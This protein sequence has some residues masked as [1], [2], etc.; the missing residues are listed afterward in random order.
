MRTA[1]CQGPQLVNGA[2][3]SP[4][5]H[6]LRRGGLDVPPAG[7]TDRPCGGREDR[8]RARGPGSA[9]HRC[10]G[11][12][13]RGALLPSL[14]R[15]AMWRDGMGPG[16]LQPRRSA[17]HGHRLRRH[18]RRGA[19]HV[20]VAG[21]RGIPEPG[22]LSSQ[23][24]RRCVAPELLSSQTSWRRAAPR[25]GRV[26]VLRGVERSQPLDGGRVGSLQ[27]ACCDCLRPGPL[28][29]SRLYGPSCHAKAAAL[30]RRDVGVPAPRCGTRPRLP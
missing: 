14:C 19:P 7:A 10:Q 28:L 30:W 11:L 15:G 8:Q 16:A 2:C 20:E 22:A 23:T 13:C 3:L 17:S 6:G 26:R 24:G 25:Q 5:L 27:R 4:P 21:R 18:A 1:W 12:L 29:H 9:C